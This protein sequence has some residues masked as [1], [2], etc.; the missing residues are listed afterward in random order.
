LWLERTPL[1]PLWPI[2]FLVVLQVLSFVLGVFV[3]SW[4]GRVWPVAC[5]YPRT[6]TRGRKPCRNR[7]F[8][9]WR[10]CHLHR[11][12]W[13]RSTDS[14]Q[15]DPTLRRWETVRRGK[16]V[17]R[18]DLQG[19]GF[20][21]PKSNVIGVLYY[22]GF[23]RPPRD[24]VR[25]VP[26]LVRDYRR[27]FAELWA[28]VKQRRRG[29]AGGPEEVKR[30]SASAVT[31]GVIY[32]TQYILLVLVIAV[33]VTAIATVLR[34]RLPERQ[35][36]RVVV[37]YAA[38]FLFFLAGSAF[39]GGILGRRLKP[40]VWQ[41]DTDW[42]PRAWQDATS[43]FFILLAC[44]W[45]YAVFDAVKPLIPGWLVLIAFLLWLGA[46]PRPRRRRSRTRRRRAVTRST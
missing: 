42:L 8:G 29:R 40:G 24:V 17:E 16:K 7:V 32:C 26:Q 18:S 10:R 9:E 3:W 37:E 39:R 11:R 44:A 21:R 45:G 46:D 6:T 36:L 43:T 35:E 34:V 22:K 38:A 27:R 23:A 31:P 12:A 1:G 15:V 13:R 14:H 19:T 20:T 25:L 5:E 41:P 33:A 4:R 2:G 30:G 28:Y